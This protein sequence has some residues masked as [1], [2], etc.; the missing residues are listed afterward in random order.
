VRRRE[1]MKLIIYKGNLQGEPAAL[2]YS[3][4]SRLWLFLMGN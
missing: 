3:F 4:S 2:Q 1:G